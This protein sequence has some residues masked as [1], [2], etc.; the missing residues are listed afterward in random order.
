MKDIIT[1]FSI[2]L[3]SQNILIS[4]IVPYLWT[5]NLELK[6]EQFIWNEKI[7]HVTE[8]SDG[9][10]IDYPL[11]KVVITKD[12]KRE[13][14]LY[15]RDGAIREVN[16]AYFENELLE[17]YQTR[18]EGK[19]LRQ[20]DENN[21][22]V[23][24]VWIYPDGSRD[25]KSFTYEN[26]VLTKITARDEFG[27]ALEELIYEDNKLSSIISID[28]DGEIIM[29]RRRIYGSE[30]R[31]IESQRVQDGEI[32]KRTFYRYNEKDQLVLKEEEKINRFIGAKMPPETIEYQYHTNGVLQEERWLVFNDEHGEAI[33]YETISIYDER[34]LEI[35][36]VY[37]EYDEN[38]E[39]I[40]NYEY[41]L[42]E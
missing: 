16:T 32:N 21:N 23:S 27:V 10:R 17:V 8:I 26:S 7:T 25:E 15:D 24:E 37:K 2:V 4:Q 5:E 28:E 18:N 34:G 41:K 31:I 30:G 40:T 20:Y 3:I 11:S 42:T 12:G 29:E 6:K 13:I 9:V 14:T 22:L 33:K 35:K 36:D 1:V 39:E 19:E 38:F